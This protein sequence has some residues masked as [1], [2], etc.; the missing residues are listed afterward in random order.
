[1][2]CS[3]SIILL[4]QTEMMATRTDTHNV[5]HRSIWY[6]YTWPPLIKFDHGS[7]SWLS[8]LF[9]CCSVACGCRDWC[10]RNNLCWKSCIC[11]WSLVCWSCCAPFWGPFFLL[12]GSPASFPL[13]W[14]VGSGCFSTSCGRLQGPPRTRC[15][16]WVLLYLSCRHPC[17]RAESDLYDTQMMWSTEQG[18]L[19]LRDLRITHMDRK[20]Q[21]SSLLPYDLCGCIHHGNQYNINRN[22]AAVISPLLSVDCSCYKWTV[23]WWN[24]KTSTCPWLMLLNLLLKVTVCD[25]HTWLWC[26]MCVCVC[27]H[28]CVCVCLSPL[29]VYV[30]VCVYLLC[31]CMCV[32]LSPLC[33]YVHVCVWVCVCV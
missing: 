13:T 3:N 2:Y 20:S 23:G 18:S 8:C 27:V 28:V 22:T 17:S 24:W 21:Q 6:S 19:L 9:D 29:Y 15:W 31:M 10:G 5:L 32:C 7:T 33:V 4:Q 30:C 14:G 12:L 16:C 1:M 25:H 11:V 26:P